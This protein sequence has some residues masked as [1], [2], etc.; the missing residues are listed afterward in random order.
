TAA[1]SEERDKWIVTAIACSGGA[2][3]AIQAAGGLR[4]G[5][6]RNQLLTGVGWTMLLLRRYDAAPALWAESGNLAQFPAPI[7]T[8]MN[9]LKKYPDLQLRAADPRSTVLDIF[10]AVID[11]QH[12][13]PAFWDAQLESE[14]RGVNRWILPVPQLSSAWRWFDDVLQSMLDITIEGD[15][16]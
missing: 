12:K 1:G 11:L 3:A 6:S 15:A 2:Q 5:A 8:M 13:A 9:K 16:G 10:A 4:S 7:A 14:F